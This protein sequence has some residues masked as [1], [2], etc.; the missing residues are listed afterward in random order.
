MLQERI[1]NGTCHSRPKFLGRVTASDTCDTSKTFPYRMLILTERIL[2][3]DNGVCDVVKQ[4]KQQRQQ[5]QLQQSSSSTRPR[6]SRHRCR[7]IC[8]TLNSKALSANGK[9]SH[10]RMPSG[11]VNLRMCVRPC[12]SLYICVS[13]SPKR[14]NRTANVFPGHKLD[15]RHLHRHHH[16]RSR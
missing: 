12:E 3:D 11:R 2:H 8:E 9:C 14:C 5:Q 4:Q 13:L 15:S 10:V 6:Y 7:R 1:R 16:H